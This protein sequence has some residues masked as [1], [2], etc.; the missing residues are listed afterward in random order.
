MITAKPEKRAPDRKAMKG[1]YNSAFPKKERLPW[2][3]LQL[4]ATLKRADLTA[5]YDD[6]TFCGFTFSVTK[7]DC[8]YVM[9]FAVTE[10]LRGQ[11]C[12]SAILKYIKQAN[13]GKTIFLVAE[14]PDAAAPNYAQRI[15]R[16]AFYK[17]NGFYDTGLNGREVGGIFRVLS[18]TGTITAKAYRQVFMKLT[19]GIWR[20]KVT[21]VNQE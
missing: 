16:L 18:S 9:F 4:W 12:G 17:K 19:F 20:P 8:F 10:H 15:K 7:A 13:L 11:G 21:K 5:Y 1:L 2:G 6:D 3:L 14:L